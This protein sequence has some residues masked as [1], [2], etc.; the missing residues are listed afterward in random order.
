MGGRTASWL[1]RLPRLVAHLLLTASA[2]L[3]A[4]CLLL[5]LAAPLLH[6]RPLIFTSGSMSPTI[7]SGSLALARE[8]PAADLAVGDVV[9]VPVQGTWVTHRVVQIEHRPGVA[10]LQLRGDANDAPDPQVYRVSSAPRTFVHV[11]HA[12]RAVATL[13]SPVGVVVL[14]VVVAH[15]WGILRRPPRGGT[16]GGR[17]GTRRRERE[18]AGRRRAPALARVGVVGAAVAVLVSPVVALPAAQA[19]WS[20][21]VTVSGATLATVTP[22]TTTVSCGL[23]N[24]GSTTLTWAAVP[25]ATGY[26]LSFGAGGATTQD[27]AAGTLSKTFTGTTSGTFSV[28]AVFGSTSWLSASS[29]SK[30]YT[31]VVGLVGTCL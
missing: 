8:T 26:R 15:L 27:V 14:G 10:L 28:Q 1:R 24:V 4:A 7:P 6:L 30:S 13:S 20:D 22:S 3:G 29:N 31:S 9:T 19:A 16:P 2:V 18:P 23:L 21:A 12:G 5:A 17:S 11:A 25:H